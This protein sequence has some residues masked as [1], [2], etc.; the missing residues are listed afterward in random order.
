MKTISVL[1]VVRLPAGR[2]QGQVQSY[3]LFHSVDKPVFQG[4]FLSMAA[5]D[6]GA[7]KE[8]VFAF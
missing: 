8:A 1:Q 4:G 5:L 6:N 3:V 2:L 7:S